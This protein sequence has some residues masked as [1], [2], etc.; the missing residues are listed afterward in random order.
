M[1]PRL[2]AFFIVQA[3]SP[4]ARVSTHHEQQIQ[5]R[6]GF[7]PQAQKITA[8]G[9]LQLLRFYAEPAPPPQ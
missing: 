4:H 9:I 6:F 2:F 5:D 7:E 8:H 1:D 3:T